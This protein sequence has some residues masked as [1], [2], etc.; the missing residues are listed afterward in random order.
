MWMQKNSCQVAIKQYM[1]V[2]WFWHLVIKQYICLI[3]WSRWSKLVWRKERGT[4][5]VVQGLGVPEWW[6]NFFE[7]L[8]CTQATKSS[9]FDNSFFMGMH[10]AQ[11]LLSSSP[12]IQMMSIFRALCT[13]HINPHSVGIIETCVPRETNYSH[14]HEKGKLICRDLRSLQLYYRAC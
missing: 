7:C 9:S 6:Q 5:I 11:T 13:L 12:K 3:F 10:I 1:N 8:G 4:N 14:F 2:M